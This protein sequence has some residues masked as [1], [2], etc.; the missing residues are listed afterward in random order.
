MSE[1]GFRINDPNVI[2]QLFA[3]E[4][5]AIHLTTGAY[6]SLPGIAGEAFQGLVPGGATL[7][8]IATQLA[9]RYDAQVDTIL[10]DLGPFFSQLEQES[11]VVRVKLENGRTSPPAPEQLSPRA[12][13]FAPHLGT[14]NDLQ[15]LFLI[16]PIHDVSAAGWPNVQP[17]PAPAMSAQDLSRAEYHKSGPHVIFE[18]MGDETVLMNLETAAYYSVS[19]PAEDVFSLIEEAPN[20]EEM[21]LAL[22][23]T[24][25]IRETELESALQT[26]LAELTEAGLIAPRQP[27]AIRAAR[28]LTINRPGTGLP[29]I[30]MRLASFQESATPGSSQP[31]GI[32]RFRMRSNDLL[33]AS[34]GGEMVMADRQFGDYYRLNQPAIDIFSLLTQQPLRVE[35][36]VSALLRKYDAPERHLTAAVIIF[37]RNLAPI[38]LV[39]IEGADPAEQ[40]SVPVFPAVQPRVPF[41]G[42]RCEVHKDLRELMSPF[43]LHEYLVKPTRA[44]STAFFLESLAEYFAET[45]KPGTERLLTIAGCG[46]RLRSAN[47]ALLEEL[48][49]AGSHLASPLQSTP[50]DLN[51]HIWD[52]AT[53]PSDPYFAS[54]LEK[55][56]SNWSESC[57][58]RGELIGIHGDQ[59]SAVYHPG[60]DILSVVDRNS[61][62][63]F[64]L[65]RD[66]SPLPYWEIGSPFRYIFHSWFAARGLQFV[67]GGAV[68]SAAGGV[69]LTAKGGSG[70]STTTMLCAKAGMQFAGDDYCLADPRTGYLHS[71]YN[72]TKLK[73]TE[74]LTRLPEVT[75]L[76]RNPDSFENGGFGKA[77]YFLS[78]LWND[79]LVSG[80]PLRAVLIPTVTGGVDSRLDPCSPADALMAMMP[81]TVAQLPDAGQGD[82]ERIAA[83]VQ[84]LPAY[85][86]HLGTD[87]AQIP[88]LVQQVLNQ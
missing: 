86:L 37:L 79:R 81:S 3:D 5:V 57:G 87:V 54:I 56:F 67:H 49:K 16:D 31:A 39:V 84:K 83:L 28:R 64:F 15:E 88:P 20:S 80:F 38:N 12:P 22:L 75:G 41:V 29:F 32:V 1:T 53:P 68:G 33:T 47:P 25:S 35:Q 11:L 44:S 70:K 34:A 82:S 61:D 77:I 55:L 9:S 10:E 26:Y 19:G 17:E 14:H 45:S 36:I 13:Y 62:R 43:N 7:Q 63:A 18:K 66:R 30:Q 51:V 59:L 23:S 73:G 85:R 27:A 8:E 60:P 6:H 48:T 2:Y 74:D 71:L 46:V 24:Y 78:E 42:F 50:A 58:P 69:L 4:T 65:K 52:A 76:S 72:S 21:R 40:S